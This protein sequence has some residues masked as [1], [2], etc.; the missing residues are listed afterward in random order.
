MDTD[1]WKLETSEPCKLEESRR[2]LKFWYPHHCLPPLWKEL[3]VYREHRRRYKRGARAC[4]FK[5]VRKP[6]LLGVQSSKAD[7][8]D[9]KCGMGFVSRE[10]RES[11]PKYGSDSAPV[12][13]LLEQQMEDN[14]KVISLTDVTILPKVGGQGGETIVG[15]L[16]AHVNGFTYKASSFCMHFLFNNI[17]IPLFRLGDK[18]MP[19]LVHFHLHEPIMMGAEETRDIQFYLVQCSVGQ[20]RADHDSV[21]IEK[22]KQIRDGGHNEDLKNFVH[23]VNDRWCSLFELPKLFEEIDKK[24]EFYGVLP[25]KA[26]VTFALTLFSLIVFVETPFA[27]VLRDIEIVNLA[28]LRLGE[29][30][31]T[32]IFKDFK[33]ENVIEINSIS[34]DSLTD[35]THCLRHVQYYVNAKK[36]DWRSIV[37]DVEDCPEKFRENGGWDNFKLEDSAYYKE[38][39]SD[40]EWFCADE[41][42]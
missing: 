29:I 9:K 4:M 40:R 21:K 35:I 12:S 17:K 18:R 28:L 6:R 38:I 41:V 30:D 31:M 33:E 11:V 13:A 27:V 7:S 25:S 5:T 22:E 36:P 8:S 24:Y 14:H 20:K 15:T 10:P 1:A 39:E 16:E 2:P 32:V 23:K 37:K 42:C 3:E 34:L 26:P 19:P